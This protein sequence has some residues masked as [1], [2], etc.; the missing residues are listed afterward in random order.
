MKNKEN[1]QSKE[2]VLIPMVI[3]LDAMNENGW[4]VGLNASKVCQSKVCNRN[5]PVVLVPG[6]K[7]QYDGIM[8][9]YSKEFKADDRDKRCAIGD[10][11][12]KLIR[13]PE[14]NKCSECKYY[15][16]RTEYG[17][18]LFCDLA[19]E[20]D[21][22]EMIDYNAAAPENY[23]DGDRYLRILADLIQHVS[24]IDPNFA[25]M[26]KLLHDGKSRRE[27]AEKMKLPKSTVIDQVAKLR[28][29]T[30]EFFDNLTY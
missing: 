1:L 29:I 6:T 25:T 21:D 18:A 23:N 26:I 9:S 11:H 3:D 22:G 2:T 28:K 5:L 7:E 24:E 4:I 12:G 14:C 19:A 27:V 10:G 8:S 17:T 15:Y 20:G 16:E 13:C 30:D